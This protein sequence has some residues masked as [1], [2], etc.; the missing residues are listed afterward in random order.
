MDDELGYDEGSYLVWIAW[1]GYVNIRMGAREL[2]YM[3]NA[4]F[5]CCNCAGYHK[6]G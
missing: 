4:L 6:K 2:P 5:S 1:I 3:T